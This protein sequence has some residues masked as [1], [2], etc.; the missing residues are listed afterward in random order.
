M[1]EVAVDEASS[2]AGDAGGW[3]APLA[4][5]IM[6]A[7]ADKNNAKVRLL[8]IP[9]RILQYH[10]NEQ[11]KWPLMSQ[12]SNPFGQHRPK[13][14]P[15]CNDEVGK[16]TIFFGIPFLAMVVAMDPNYRSQAA[17]AHQR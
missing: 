14:S 2:L 13:F 4:A 10:V 17:I 1:S 9:T 8:V 3:A 5:S 12:S 16:P 7:R 11:E 6:P 15:L